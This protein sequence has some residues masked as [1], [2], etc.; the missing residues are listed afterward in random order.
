MGTPL[1]AHDLIQQPLPSI[2]RGP[3]MTKNDSTQN[4][5]FHSTLGEWRNFEREVREAV[6]EIPWGDNPPALAYTPSRKDRDNPNHVWHEQLFCGDGHSVVG[7]FG[8][9]AGHV[10]TSVC[11][12]I[13]GQIRFADYKASSSG[14]EQ[15]DVPDITI[16]TD[17]GHI[18]VLGEAKTPWRHNILEKLHG[19]LPEFRHYLGESR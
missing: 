12:S 16:V 19:D 13:G 15:G 14:K 6:L 3:Y 18:R 5:Y 7:R 17:S 8:Q 2:K 4:I 11:R 10:M 1:T 9:I